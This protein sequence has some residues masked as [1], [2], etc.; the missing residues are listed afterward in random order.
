MLFLT[1]AR[2]LELVRNSITNI[3]GNFYLSRKFAHYRIDAGNLQYSDKPIS[4]AIYMSVRNQTF[5]NTLNT[6][7]AYA[8]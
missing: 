8:R 6:H 7:L 5:L 1:I 2:M 3:G 4:T